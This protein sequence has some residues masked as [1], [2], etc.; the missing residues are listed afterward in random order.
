VI[1]SSVQAYLTGVRDLEPSIANTLSHFSTF[2][3]KAF[4]TAFDPSTPGMFTLPV[5][6]SIHNWATIIAGH[7]FPLNALHNI[8]PRNP[9]KSIPCNCGPWGRDTQKVWTDLGIRT[10]YHGFKNLSVDKCGYQIFDRIKDTVERFVAYC[11]VD[12]RTT[13][14]GRVRWPSR[15]GDCELVT[16]AVQRLGSAEELK[17]DRPE[18][19]RALKCRTNQAEW[20]KR[21]GCDRY[22]MGTLGSVLRV[23]GVEED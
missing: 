5:C 23:L 6:F 11:R 15:S 4:S 19:H 17:R 13:L 21:R 1:T 7:S 2:S 18:V 20:W 14:A 10:P 12:V 8:T 9:I 16:K 22:K 3:A